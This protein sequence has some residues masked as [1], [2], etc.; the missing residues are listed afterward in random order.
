[1][2]NVVSTNTLLGMQG[3]FNG[4]VIQR[5]FPSETY[6]LMFVDTADYT[7]TFSTSTVATITSAGRVPAWASCPTFTCSVTSTGKPVGSAWVVA[8]GNV[9]FTS[10]TGDEVERLVMFK[11]G[12]DEPSSYLVAVWDTVTGLPYTPTGGDVTVQWS[13]NGIFGIYEF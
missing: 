11:V 8:S 1:M 12:A 2:A 5:Y 10:L 7:P 4:A 13:T 6:A 9:T 3:S